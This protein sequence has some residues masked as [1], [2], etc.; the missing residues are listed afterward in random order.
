MNIFLIK[1]DRLEGRLVEVVDFKDGH[2]A[3][4]EEAR[5][6]AERD[7]LEAD[8]DMEI[9]TLEADSIEE[10]RETHGSYFTVNSPALPI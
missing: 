8:R 2:R 5:F 9:V 10:L 1:F 7:A 6:Q 4:A 3:E